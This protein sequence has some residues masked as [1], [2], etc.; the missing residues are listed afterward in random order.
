[1]EE[2]SAVSFPVRVTG[3]TAVVVHAE[4]VGGHGTV[5]EVGEVVVMQVVAIAGDVDVVAR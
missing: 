4:V 2:G 1:M 5:V 3:R